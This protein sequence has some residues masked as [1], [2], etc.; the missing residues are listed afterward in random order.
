MKGFWFLVA[1]SIF[2]AF[3]FFSYLVHKDLFINFDF[4]TTVRLQDNIPRRFD[5][6][7]STLSMLG[8]FEILVVILGVLLL[9]KRN[10]GLM[11]LVPF[12]FVVLH[13]IEIFGKL[14]V[15]HPGPPFMFLRT[16]LPFSF[17][18]FYVQ[19]GFS[20]PSG[21]AARTAFLSVI[22]LY[23]LF[24]TKKI[25]LL[26]KILIA[27]AVVSFDIAMFVSR[28]YLGEHWTTDVIGG[29][30]LGAA[31]GLLSVALF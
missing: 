14:Y 3:V 13:L 7:F 18:S 12:S 15:R 20:Y 17:P 6:F 9:L 21:H 19:P 25:G 28:A 26:P 11:I 10:L 22:V 2:S 29:V 8:S 23:F 27:S 5:S 16:D 31:L 24:K 1:L 30:L 4:D